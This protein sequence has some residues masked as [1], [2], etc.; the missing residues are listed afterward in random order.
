MKKIFFLVIILKSIF[1]TNLKAEIAYIDINY[2]L[3]ESN[4]GKFLNSHVETKRVQYKKKFKELEDQ[5]IKKEKSLMAKQNIIDKQEFENQVKILTT[6]VQKYRKDKQT[7]ID[8]LNK[9]KIENTKEILKVLN[10]IITNFVN[11]NSI[12]IVI[13]KKNIIVGKKN[14]DITDEILKLLNNNISKLNL[15]WKTLFSKKKLMWI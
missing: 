1:L 7:N 9:F 3:K 10:P 5:L 12:S 6:Q 8:D 2:I 14:L 15:K 13:P 4:V 11:S